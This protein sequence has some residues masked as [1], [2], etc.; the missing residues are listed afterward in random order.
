M[1]GQNVTLDNFCS[2]GKKKNCGTG[3]LNLMF[4]N[5]ELADSEQ[6]SQQKQFE[7]HVYFK[8][9]YIDVYV[10]AAFYRAGDLSKSGHL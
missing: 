7:L 9:L 5:T 3:P 2:L 6:C 1:I 10:F 8:A 4:S